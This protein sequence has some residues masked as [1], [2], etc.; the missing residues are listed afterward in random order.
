MA[1][2][3]SPATPTGTPTA[4]PGYEPMGAAVRSDAERWPTLDAAGHARLQALRDHPHSP[5]WTHACG[6]LLTVDDQTALEAW[7]GRLDH[8]TGWAPRQS[9]SAAQP[10]DDARPPSWLLDELERLRQV[11]PWLRRLGVRTWA[12]VPVIDRADLAGA[13]ADFVPVDV[14][15]DRVV[16][17]TSSGSTGS[18]LVIPWHPLDIAKD[19]VL[20]EHLL[21]GIGVRW[22]PERGRLGLVNLVE[23]QQAFTYASMMTA[24]DH[25]PMARVSLHPGAWRDPSD[26]RA[27]LTAADPQVVSG[28]ALTLLS[29][30]ALDLPV[31]P[32][33][34]LSGA[35]ELSAPARAHL[36]NALGCP[37]LDLYGLRETGPVAC[38]AAAGAGHG[39][40]PRRVWV[41]VVDAAGHA[42]P[43]GT[44]GEVVVSALEN[45]Y[46]PLLRYRTGDR[47]ALTGTGPDRRLVGLEGRAAVR[48]RSGSGGLV[49]SVELTQQLQ[50][51]GILAW[52][53]HQQSDGR[54]TLRAVGG[55]PTAAAEALSALLD[56]P[57]EPQV[58]ASTAD[59]GPG[60]PRRFTSDAV[61]PGFEP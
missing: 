61:A 42:A 56:Q 50:R 58:A 4:L 47:A 35:V 36:E 9:G 12:D 17:G 57:V 33:A 14:P 21:T 34:A 43:D 26:R 24:R 20:I 13:V 19:L 11:V 10:D 41:E 29:Y 53:V 52:T 59:L 23:Q 49:Q 28:S 5:T 31:R 6:D 30:A 54:L 38:E 1:V 46:L 22:R 55:D 8:E 32:L 25:Q 2:E 48:F 15:L 40:V 3:N 45:P 37:V 39:L 27:F 51:H 60:K 44:P 16:Q 7:A 18:A